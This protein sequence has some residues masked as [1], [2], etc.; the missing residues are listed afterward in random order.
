MD[1]KAERAWTKSP[2]TV[3]HKKATPLYLGS[4]DLSVFFKGRHRAASNELVLYVVRMRTS[5]RS[6]LSL[7][8][9][10]E[11]KSSKDVDTGSFYL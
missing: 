1:S 11:K 2:K 3:Q 5:F 10:K 7:R 8:G 4:R 6:D 9:K